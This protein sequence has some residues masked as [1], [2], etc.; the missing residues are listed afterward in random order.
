MYLTLR[1]TPGA[2]IIITYMPTADRPQSQKDTAYD[3]L[4]NITRKRINKGPIYIL[5][6]FNARLIYPSTEEEELIMGKHTM[7]DNSETVDELAD[8][9]RDNRDQLITFCT[10]NE[11]RVTNTMYRN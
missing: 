7:H 10:T 11:L 5:G 3:K 1:G 9:V 4:E 8:N 6:D 2:S